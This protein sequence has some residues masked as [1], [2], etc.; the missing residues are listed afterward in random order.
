MLI[1]NLHSSTLIGCGGELNQSECLHWGAQKC[2]GV[3]RVWMVGV[4]MGA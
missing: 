3:H 2:T 1:S 4:Y